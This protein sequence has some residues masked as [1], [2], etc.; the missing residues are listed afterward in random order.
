[1]TSTKGV[2]TLDEVARG[3]LPADRWS[4]YE[5]GR[6]ALEERER[7]LAELS[8]AERVARAEKERARLAAEAR[9]ELMAQRAAQRWAMWCGQVPAIYVDDR[10][11]PEKRDPRDF[12]WWLS[13]LSADQHP[14]E[15]AAWLR[16]RESRTLWLIGNT[17]TG[18]THAAVAAG[19]AAAAHAVHAR[20]VSQLDYLRQLRPGGSDEPNRVRERFA[21]T[22]LL[23][24]D[25]FGAET[26]DASQFVRQE[27]LSLLDERL[28]QGRRQ[29]ITTNADAPE[30]C[31]IFGDR[32][33]SRLR[34]GAA[35]LK[36]Q[37]RDRRTARQ[38]W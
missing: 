28:S 21:T 16:D 20:Y 33:M 37:G 22:S 29:I 38:P 32:I 13:G 26:G 35:R 8:A 11:D 15:I 6:E 7:E 34:A 19:Y 4:E 2:A 12:D 31:D 27:L 36:F 1:V 10:A 18:K 24:L 3:Q 5:R 14:A 17:G 25:D 23:V 9:S 30:L